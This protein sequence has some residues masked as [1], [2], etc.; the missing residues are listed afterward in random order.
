MCRNRGGFLLQMNIFF[1]GSTHRLSELRIVLLGHRHSGKS[2][3]GHTILNEEESEL[4]RT[5]QC[6]KRQGEVAGRHITVVEAPG[7]WSNVPV[8]GSTELLK[9]ETVL[10]V[11]LSPPGPHAVLLIISVDSVFK[12]TC[13]SILEGYLNLL[14]DTVWSHTIVLFTFG[15]CLGDTPI[16]QHIESEG[17]ELQWLVEKCGNRYHVLNN[18]NSSDDTQV[19]ELL[20]K[21]EE[22]VA[23]NSG[24]HFE[25]DRKILQEM[26]EKRRADEERVKE[27]MMKTFFETPLLQKKTH[28]LS[29]L[30][31]VLLGYINAGKSSAGNTILNREEFELKRTAQCV[32]RQGEVAGRHITVVEAPGWWSDEPVEE[33]T[34]LL[35]QETVL[36]VSLCPPGPHAVLLIIR[37]DWV[38]DRIDRSV[39]EGYLNLL[40]DTV[41]SH[42]IVLFTFGDCLGDT[43]IEQHIESEGKELQWLVEKCGNRYHVLNNENRSDDT[44]VTELL[45]KIEEMVAANSGRHFEMDRKIL[46]EVEEKRRAEEERVKERMMKVQKQRRCN[47]LQMSSRRRLTELRIVLLGHRH[48]GKSS[49]G[50]TILNRE[51]SELKRTAQCVKRQ[52]EVAGRHI[53]V[54]E[55]P[56]W[57]RNIPVEES[58]E[59][60]KQETVLS[61]SLYPPGPHAVLLAIRVDR[62]FKEIHRSI[63]EG[64]LKLL[65]DTVWSH[66]IVLFTFGDCLGDTPIEQHIESEGKE[67][68]WLVEK[69][70]NRFQVLNNENRSDDTQVTEL[71][72]KIEEMVAAN[73]GRHFEMDRKILQEVEERRRAREERVK[74]R[75]MKVQ[76]QRENFKVFRDITHHLSEIR[77]VLLGSRAAGRSSAGNTILN[78][79]EFELKRS[80]QCV[81]RQGDVAGRHITVVETPGWWSNVP[82]EESTELLKQETVLSVSLCPP[83]PHAVLLIMRVDRVF[84]ENYRSVLEGYLNLLTD[85][86]WSHTIV[87]FTFGDWL[88]DTPIEQHIESEGKELQWLVEKCGNRYHV[89]NNKN[90]SDDTQVTEL[91][92]KIEEMVAA[93]SGRHFEM[94]RKILQEVE[95]KRRAREERVKERMM[96]VQRQRENFKVFRDIT[97]YLSELRIVV[98]GS[99]AAGKSS[100]GN[101]ILNREEFE[102]KGTAQCVKRQGDVAGRRITVVEAPGWWSIVPV[103]ESTELLK[104]EIVLS[105]SLCPPGPHAVLLIIRVEGVCIENY[106]SVLG[107]YLKILTDTVWSHTIVLFTCGDCL[108][109]TPIEQYIESEGKGLQWLV[110]K[111]G[112]R[113]HVLN[114]KNRSDDTQVTGLLEKIEEMV[115]ANSGRHFEV[116]RKILQEVEEK[117]KAEEERVKERMMKVQKQRRCN[118]LQMSSRR[119]LSELRIVLLG[120]RHSGKSSAGN[121]ILNEEESELKR[122]AQCVKRQG[123]VAGR[124]ITVV[125]APGWWNNVPVE[126]STELLKQETVL[127]VSLCPPGPHAVLLIIRVDRVF[128][129]THRSVLGVYLKLLTD[130]VWSHTIVLFTFGDCLGDTPIEQHIESEGK[131]L[132]WLVEK[133][134][135]RYH[136]LNN[137]NKSDDIQVTELLEK[138]EEMVAANSGRPFEINRKILQEVEKKR[139]A[140]EERV[141]ERMMKVQKQRR[142]NQLQMSSRKRLSELRIVLL[143]HRHS[144]KSS[145]GNTILNGEESELKRTAQCVKRQGEVAGRHI[146]VVEAPGWWRNIPVEESAELLKEE[147]VLSVSLCP[148]GPHAVLLA[149]RVD[150]VFKEIY[151]SV[152]VGY[153]NLLTDTVWSHTVVLF[154]CGD[155]LGDTPIEQHIESEGKDL[156]WLLEKCGNRYHVLN[157][158]NRSDDI[159]VTELLEKIEEMVAAN[160]GRH[161]VMDRKILQEVESKRRAVEERVKERMMKVQRQRENF[162]VFRDVTHHLSELRIVLLGSRAAGKSS[163]GNTILNREEFELKRTAQCVKRQGDVAGRHITVVEAPGW[164]NVP[165]EESTE[166]LKQEIVLSV[167]LCPP[168]P[169]AVLLIIRVDL[170]YIENYRCV[171]GGYLN[172]LTDTVWSHTIVLFTCGDCL[173]DTPIEQHIESEGKELQWLLEKCGNRYHVLNNKNRS[174]DTQVTELLEKIEEMV[175]ANSGRH[176]EMDRKILQEV[177]KNRTAGEDRVKER[178]MKVQR[179]RENFKVSRDITHH[180]SE[181]KIVLLGYRDAGKSS[182]GNTI[183][184]REEFELKSTAQ[185]VKRQGEVAGRHITV[186]EA[187]GWWNNYTVENSTELLK[188]EIV[189]SVSLCPPGPHA[190]LLIIRVDSVCKN[191]RSVL[192]GYLKLLTDTVW[193]HT[194]V[195][196]SGGDRLGDT[197]IELHIESEG[198]E[199]QWLVEKCGNR[200]HVFNNKNRSDDTQ[201]TELLEKIEEMVA[202]NSGRH[203]EMGKKILQEV[204]EKRRAGEE[205]VKERRMKVQRQRENFKVFRDITH[206]LSELKIVLLGYRHSGKSSSGNTILNREE[207]ELKSTAQCVKRQGEVAGRHITV[208]EAPG[209]W[210]NYTVQERTELLKQEIVLS[211][212]LCPPGPHAVLLIIRVDFLFKEN[213]RRVLE[214]YLNLLTDTV[215]SHT[216]V[217]F[218]FGDCLGDTPIEQHIESEGKELQWLVEKCGN[219]YHVL[220]N[221]NRSDDTQVTEL[222]E[223][224][225][226]MVAANSGRHFEMDRKI[227]QGV[228]E[229]RR[230]EE[231]RVNE[232]MMKVQRQRENFKVFRDITHHLSELGIVL[233]GSRAAGKSSAGNTILNREEF[234]LKRTAQ[235]V[236]RQGEVAG[237][238]ITVVEAPGWWNTY[239][240]EESTE[241]LKQEIVLSVSLCPPGPHAVLLIIRVDRVFKETYR[242]VLEG[243]LNLLTDTVWSHTIVLF[244]CGDCLLDTPI[245]Q[246]I[247]SEGKELQWLV[248]KCGNRYHVLNNKNR[249]DDTQVTELLEKIEEMVAANN[250]R[251]FEVDRK[252]LQEME[253]KRRSE[254][255]RV[256]VRRMK[257]QKQREAIRAQMEITHYLSEL[258][259]V[260]LGYKTAGKSSA[261][262][263]ILNREEFEL[264]RTAQCVKR[265]GDVA[266]RHITV[267]EAPGWWSD[268]PVEER[269][270][271][272]KQEIVLSVS[273]CP[274][275]PH[276]VLL[277]IRVDWVRKENYRSVLEG[278]LNLLTDTVWSHTIVLF[279]FGDWLGDTPIE[280]HIESEGKEL[281]WLVEKCGNRYHVLNNKNRNDDTQV[282]ELLE[283][284]EEMV[285]A[286]SGRHFEMDRKILQEVEVK[287]RAEEERA[288][289]RMMKVQRQRENFKVFR[290]KF[291]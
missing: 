216:I 253:E 118:Q 102:L 141:K 139:R 277:A 250:G 263:T 45:E 96:K 274:P 200:Y 49:S 183:L 284:I 88:G 26:E 239:T 65:T 86:V 158:E 60:L 34:E 247:E 53:T 52:G 3:A 15:D 125:E 27:R 257:V 129:E 68:Q 33:S 148:P 264:K 203:F 273:L 235:C 243:Y 46:Q 266:G 260:L 54:V 165:V 119:R 75:M 145:A 175:A 224:I 93:N 32:K 174:D 206:H 162:K 168:G 51:E 132:Q 159:Q 113:Y 151:R 219:R 89:L 198:K 43:P 156:Q 254:E 9:Q 18:K 161:L 214:G 58:T 104:Q 245:E 265:Q 84:K 37:V 269:T 78:R 112:N 83:G 136:V 279:T 232:R 237:R 56:G 48:T 189:L 192:E 11:S 282:T 108:G 222:L 167:S 278:Y 87:L 47:Q 111:C 36:S 63:L 227:L 69:C 126:E 81:K 190:V 244:T 38:F 5:A 116:D 121:T 280:Q 173:G 44:Q 41:W 98:L 138:I 188:Q 8:E 209:W 181:L 59:L 90:R 234:E 220:N 24:R 261:G 252:I 153:L 57:C 157:N 115:A 35:K 137:E 79:E 85:T 133:C 123:E 207:F 201:V 226:E 172:L 72:E 155:W 215:W 12:E 199:L 131:E 169:H 140:E 20:E 150:R 39:L 21:I 4:K 255:E 97:H 135:N 55:A 197:P 154:T 100:A 94:D 208:V 76:R 251:H 106:R 191:Y 143:G 211:M 105:V 204:E 289:E 164:S 230:A 177:E 272:L 262:N 178:M 144:G 25:M 233:L 179:Q 127:S 180:L 176:F 270:E 170:V 286:N 99:R 109:D 238:H 16:E 152:L 248:E 271:L 217:L 50:N 195:L 42:T 205:R 146:T 202:A 249:S 19:T 80:A 240:V 130:T 13:R 73:S 184:N 74:E 62:V 77:I 23:V 246:H 160:S 103:E 142:C 2:S 288:K 114:N 92:E 283:K 290:G 124:H 223:K 163:A 61:V 186:V 241:L 285:A 101:T 221:E 7:W 22:M 95:E 134:G 259:I 187:P 149:I 276:A 14:T 64:Y 28:Y 275:G 236:K 10:S 6:V 281:Q 228:E 1:S 166:L 171:L 268:E 185:C 182:S 258:K 128:K 242:S 31:I 17:K 122:T 194:V 231:E 229:K 218:T 291:I 213:Y 70:G 210:N 91:L 225:E 196:F 267:V 30:R 120:H 212:S 29:E 67:L 256:K 40:T 71:L 107:G 193:S 82:V 147:I 66:T 117:R 110:E 287:R